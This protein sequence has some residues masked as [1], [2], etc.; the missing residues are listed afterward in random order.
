MNSWWLPKM[1]YH[2]WQRECKH[3]KNF[4]ETAANFRVTAC[5]ALKKRNWMLWSWI[6]RW[7]KAKTETKGYAN[8]WISD[9]SND[10]ILNWNLLL[11]H[12]LFCLFLFSLHNNPL[13][14]QGLLLIE[15]SRSH[16]VGFLWTSDQPDTETSNWQHSQETDIHAPGGIRTPQCHQVNGRRPTP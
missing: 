5:Q 14:G 8:I 11:M 3:N 10:Y 9:S 2:F 12:R 6:S 13:V 16:F 15:A 1:K 4:T 7:Q